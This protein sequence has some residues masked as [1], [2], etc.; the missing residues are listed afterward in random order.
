MKSVVWENNA[1]YYTINGRNK[2]ICLIF[3]HGFLENH[4]IWKD[5]EPFF[6]NYTK[7]CIDLPTHGKST[8]QGEICEMNQMAQAVDSILSTENIQNPIIIGHSMG[9][10]VALELMKLRKAK[11]IL[12]HSNFWDDDLAKKEDRNRVVKVVESNLSLFLKEA[13]PNLF[14]ENNRQKCE[15]AIHK[16]ISQASQMNPQQIAAATKGMRDRFNNSKWLEN[17]F[18]DIFIIQ[19]END[20]IIPLDKMN[21]ELSQLKNKPQL[22]N[23]PNCGHMSM[24]EQK[25]KLIELIKEII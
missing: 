3:L 5:I 6:E 16:L 9:G 14:D 25:E 20:G 4:S 21:K 23:I 8:F 2:E 13:I 1:V 12:L 11:T 17:N 19:G 22:Y 7:I 24:W 18:Q 10:Y 15:R